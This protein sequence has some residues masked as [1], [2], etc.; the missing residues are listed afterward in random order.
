M[1]PFHS[2]C[3][4][5]TPPPQDNRLTLWLP[6]VVPSTLSH[7]PLTDL[8]LKHNFHHVSPLLQIPQWL[9]NVYLVTFILL[10]LIFMAL[11]NVMPTYFSIF[12]LPPVPLQMNKSLFLLVFLPTSCMFFFFC[13]DSHIPFQ[14]DI[15]CTCW[16]AIHPS[17]AHLKY[18]LLTSQADP[19]GSPPNTLWSVSQ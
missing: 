3:R 11:H 15:V 9:P 6:P 17:I 19:S 7:L 2:A 8:S 16:N 13:T 12:F 18:F 4:S 10:I 14:S 5:C 1:I